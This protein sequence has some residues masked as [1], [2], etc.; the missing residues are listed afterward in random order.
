MAAWK[1]FVLAVTYSG[2]AIS[3]NYFLFAYMKI[4]KVLFLLVFFTNGMTELTG[5]YPAGLS[6]MCG[7][8]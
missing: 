5:T 8:G 6:C 2:N 7:Q 3:G 1:I 4:Y